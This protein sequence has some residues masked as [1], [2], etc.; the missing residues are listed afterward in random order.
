LL[1]GI[2]ADGATAATFPEARA[3]SGV[4]AAA[5]VAPDR[6]RRPP[7][8]CGGSAVDAGPGHRSD[9]RFPFN[10]EGM[11]TFTGTSGVHSTQHG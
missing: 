3:S 4:C 10:C 11:N 8:R 7:Y 6:L 9:A 1:A 5:D 2:R